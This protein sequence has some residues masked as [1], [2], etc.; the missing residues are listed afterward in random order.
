MVPAAKTK[1]KWKPK[2]KKTQ[3]KIWNL[4]SQ[5]FCHFYFI[6]RGVEWVSVGICQWLPVS[7]HFLHL[8]YVYIY[9]Y[10]HINIYIYSVSMYLWESCQSSYSLQLA[11]T[12]N[13]LANY[14]PFSS[15]IFSTLIPCNY[16]SI[17]IKIYLTRRIGRTCVHLDTYHVQI[18]IIRWL[19][20]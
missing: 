1:E 9:I 19:C 7:A 6:L 16:I 11:A 5:P 10:V 15:P 2:Q 14:F 12:F 20:P 3:N 8:L 18:Q 13:K 4:F 17:S